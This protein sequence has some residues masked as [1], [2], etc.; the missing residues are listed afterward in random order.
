MIKAIT[1]HQPWA[2]LIAVGAKP[3]ETRDWHPPRW[4][5]GQRIAIHAGKTLRAI[6]EA[7]RE[8]L[9]MDQAIADALDL[10][11]ARWRNLP[12]GAVV[13]TAKLAGAYKSAGIGTDLVWIAQSVRGSAETPIIKPDYVGDY[14][15]GRW[16]WYLTDVE[17]LDPPVPAR[18]A[19]G[20]WDWTPE[21]DHAA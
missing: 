7:Q 10:P 3:F 9:E 11:I 17:R 14:S 8:P 4:L 19:Q 6:I 18:G 2:S 13:C 16:L 20:F 1:L 5:I 15:R 21:A 12:L